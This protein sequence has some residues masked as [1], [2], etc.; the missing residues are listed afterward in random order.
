M[1]NAFWRGP[2]GGISQFTTAKIFQV[3]RLDVVVFCVENVYLL[4][5]LF[6]L[7]KCVRPLHRT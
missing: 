3:V 1:T 4:C 7:A 5:E 2:V 6:A